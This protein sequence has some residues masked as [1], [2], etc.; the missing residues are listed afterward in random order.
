[1]QR[2]LHICLQEGTAVSL[3]PVT[4]LWQNFVY[5]VLFIEI[6]NVRFCLFAV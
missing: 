2:Y 6:V 1:M 4:S 5:H 3:L